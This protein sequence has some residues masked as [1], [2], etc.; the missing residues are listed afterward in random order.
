VKVGDFICI[1]NFSHGDLC[2]KYIR[3]RVHMPIDRPIRRWIPI[4]DGIEDEEVVVSLHYER[5]P[6]FCFFCGLIGHKDT[7]CEMAG[8]PKNKHYIKDLS[9]RPTVREDIRRWLLP[10][11][12]E[13]EMQADASNN[14]NWRHQQH[15]QNMLLLGQA[16]E[17]VATVAT[18]VHS[19]VK[20]T[21]AKLC[22]TDNKT[23]PSTTTLI[24]ISTTDP[25]TTVGQGSA[26][27]GIQ[28]GHLEALHVVHS[29]PPATQ[30]GDMPTQE[31]AN[32]GDVNL[33]IP[34]TEGRQVIEKEKT[35]VSDGDKTKGKHAATWK[36]RNREETGAQN[37]D[38]VRATQGTN[39]G[40]TRQREEECDASKPAKKIL[41]QVPPLEESLGVEGL[42]R[43]R[44]YEEN[45]VPVILKGIADSLSK[46]VKGGD[47]K[48]VEE[49]AENVVDKATQEP[50][51]PCAN[52]GSSWREG[53][54]KEVKSKKTEPATDGKEPGTE[55]GAWRKR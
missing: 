43:L 13:L 11:K 19:L 8:T 15:R 21:T 41:Y 32:T 14:Q 27:T 48:P 33:G 6:N 24:K 42:R 54:L 53:E 55:E 34:E 1:D 7:D 22:I 45:V 52:A 25:S 35:N 29:T 28:E 10:D 5:L 37:Y 30:V 12:T 17:T 49:V 9:V 39:L 18:E 2:D 31:K 47:Y 23:G 38:D 44:E 46:N 40:A 4:I 16:S 50:P 51:G 3:A 20:D 26:S 36:R